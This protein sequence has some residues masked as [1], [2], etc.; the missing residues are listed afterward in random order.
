MP[1]VTR[2][3]SD[4]GTGNPIVARV[5]FQWL[6]LLHW[7]DLSR[8]RREAVGEALLLRVQPRLLAAAE[9]AAKHQAA[10]KGIPRLLN[11]DHFEAIRLLYQHRS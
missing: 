1:F 3:L 8:A 11:D 4:Y 6:N 10:A 5:S 7:F 9:I 2:K